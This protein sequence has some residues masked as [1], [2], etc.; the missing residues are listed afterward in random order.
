MEGVAK[1]IFDR[2]KQELTASTLKKL[3]AMILKPGLKRFAKDMDYKEHGGAPLL[4]LAGL[5]IKAHGSSDAKAFY[6][7]IRQARRFVER[8]VISQIEEELSH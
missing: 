3:A 4:G 2:L 7:A 6:N 8:G 5:V 1:A